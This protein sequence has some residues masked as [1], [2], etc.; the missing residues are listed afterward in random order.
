MSTSRI[1]YLVRDTDTQSFYN[2]QPSLFSPDFTFVPSH[3]YAT[4]VLDAFS[5][6]CYTHYLFI[7]CF[8]FDT[9]SERNLLRRG[10]RTA[11]GR[12]DVLARLHSAEHVHNWKPLKLLQM[13]TVTIMPMTKISRYSLDDDHRT[14][15]TYTIII[16]V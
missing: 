11:A 12:N 7:F 1:I 16:I 5:C 10:L 3:T 9:E 13:M 2:P 8:D 6:Y 4:V 14:C 15:T